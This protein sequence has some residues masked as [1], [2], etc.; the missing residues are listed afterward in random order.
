MVAEA[1]LLQTRQRVGRA[2]V[3]ELAKFVREVAIGVQRGTAVSGAF[4]TPL[5]RGAMLS[6]NVAG[7]FQLLATAAPIAA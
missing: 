5:M 1:N 2:T 6:I 3:C 4:Q 7:N